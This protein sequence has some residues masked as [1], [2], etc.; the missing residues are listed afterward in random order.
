MAFSV[1]SETLLAGG[2][3]GPVYRLAGPDGSP[4]AEV[5]TGHGFNCLRWRAGDPARP[6]ELLY[7]APEWADDPAPTRSG[8]PVLF[9]FPNR[10]RDGRFHFGGRAYA[11]PPNDPAGRNAI[12]GFAPRHPWRV[13]DAGAGPDAA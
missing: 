2:R 8:V 12:H 3:A 11:L 1:T 10:I 4:S 9:P 13:L 6:D 5:W 7:A